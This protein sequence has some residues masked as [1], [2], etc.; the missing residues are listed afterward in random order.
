MTD[1]AILLK[2]E[3]RHREGIS[4]TN[5]SN[6]IECAGLATH[7]STQLLQW[8]WPEQSQLTKVSPEVLV[9]FAWSVRQIVGTQI[10]VMV[11]AIQRT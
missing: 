2:L 10:V 6:S 3:R 8:A 1:S 4:Q 9:D 7:A 11:L 5:T